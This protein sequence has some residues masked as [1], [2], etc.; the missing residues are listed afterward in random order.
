M[1]LG[2][3]AL[4]ALGL[5]MSQALVWAA[6]DAGIQAAYL[7]VNTI[8][9]GDTLSGNVD[10]DINAEYYSAENTL[11]GYSSAG[12]V[13]VANFTQSAQI[14]LNEITAGTYVDAN[15]DQHIETDLWVNIENVVNS[16]SDTGAANIEGI[17]QQAIARINTI[18]G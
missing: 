16:I 13:D 8:A 9:A 14:N 6:D 7:N 1:K 3:L 11:S 10:Q 15:I 18:G 2:T 5:A 17:T 4:W 12:T